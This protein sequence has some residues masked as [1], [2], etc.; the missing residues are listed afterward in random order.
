MQHIFTYVLFKIK[1]CNPNTY[2]RL[3]CY[4][5]KLLWT[6]SL[7]TEARKQNCGN[8]LCSDGWSQANIAPKGIEVCK[9]ALTALAVHLGVKLREYMDQKFHQSWEHFMSLCYKYNLRVL[10]LLMLLSKYM[11]QH[12]LNLP[13]NASKYWFMRYNSFWA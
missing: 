8:L 9:E 2:S 4:I 1:V 10:Y 5:P 11:R 13:N 12:K 7:G 3:V 6:T